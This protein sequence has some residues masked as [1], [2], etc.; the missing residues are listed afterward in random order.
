MGLPIIASLSH[1]FATVPSHPLVPSFLA[2]YL[3]LS[4]TS[5]LTSSIAFNIVIFFLGISVGII[6]TLV[7]LKKA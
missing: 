2:P 4:S 3:L 5:Q 7:F 6:L 1:W